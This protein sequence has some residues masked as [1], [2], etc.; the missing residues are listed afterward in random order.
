MG[1]E[2]RGASRRIRACLSVRCSVSPGGPSP[3]SSSAV[4]ANGSV[5]IGTICVELSSALE[6]RT[7]FEPGSG[8]LSSSI[9]GTKSCRAVGAPSF[10]QPRARNFVIVA[11]YQLSACYALRIWQHTIWIGL[12]WHISHI[13]YRISVERDQRPDMFLI[14]I[15]RVLLVELST[16]PRATPK[17]PNSHGRTW[18]SAGAMIIHIYSAGGRRTEEDVLCFADQEI[19]HL[20]RQ[21]DL[22]ENVRAVSRCHDRGQNG[23]GKGLFI[24][25]DML[26]SGQMGYKNRQSR[27]PSRWAGG[28]R[29]GGA[30]D[31]A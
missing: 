1:A 26:I 27:A 11:H 21:S 22:S 14:L 16:F 10:D 31:R 7:R 2:A 18:Q 29:R 8:F 19:K 28:S 4:G 12:L 25:Q 9:G 17:A 13:A 23:R 5:C 6:G 3:A 30:S 24:P 20:S 15:P